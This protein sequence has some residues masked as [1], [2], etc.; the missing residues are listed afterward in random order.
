M[1]IMPYEDKIKHLHLRVPPE[2]KK[3]LNK[4]YIIEG[5]PSLNMYSINILQKHINKRKK[6]LENNYLNNLTK[7]KKVKEIGTISCITATI[8]WLILLGIVIG[9]YIFN[10][11]KLFFVIPYITF[12]MGITA[13]LYLFTSII[14]LIFFVINRKPEVVAKKISKNN[15]IVEPNSIIPEESFNIIE[16]ENGPLYRKK[17]W[18]K[19]KDI[20]IKYD[21]EKVAC[22]RL[23]PNIDY[24][25]FIEI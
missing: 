3:D 25:A 22:I 1:I 5:F 7:I 10:E 8:E 15:K 9:I 4:L 12:L 20:E 13:S 17:L 18:K 14:S 23:H 16:T 21:K 19:M 24:F 6:M 2:M 11:T